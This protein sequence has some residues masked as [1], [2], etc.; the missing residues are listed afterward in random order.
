MKLRL[1][2]KKLKKEVEKE[3][4]ANEIVE[5][6]NGDGKMQ[7]VNGPQV[8]E[9]VMEKELKDVTLAQHNTVQSIL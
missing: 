4:L 2:V 5:A 9:N 1:E 3:K 8:R 6:I 7:E